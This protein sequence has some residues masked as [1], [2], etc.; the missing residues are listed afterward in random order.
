MKVKYTY[1]QVYEIDTKDLADFYEMEEEDFENESL[2]KDLIDS[3]TEIGDLWE[4]GT[5]IK[6]ET[7]M[8]RI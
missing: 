5:C 2:C 8:E 1:T 6:N 7:T 3:Q 4:I